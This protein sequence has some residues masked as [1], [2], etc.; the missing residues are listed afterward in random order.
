MHINQHLPRTKCKRG[1]KQHPRKDNVCQA[2]T[3]NKFEPRTERVKK[4]PRGN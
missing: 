1:T 2:N 3:P 4:N